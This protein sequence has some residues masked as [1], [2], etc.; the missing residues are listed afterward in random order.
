M[1]ASHTPAARAADDAARAARWAAVARAGLP[2]W[3][4]RDGAER[5]AR[6][7]ERAARA[8]RAAARAE[9]DGRNANPA[10]ERAAAAARSAQ[11]AAG[12]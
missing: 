4:P 1:Q 12:A 5:A 3:A 7:A 9:R 8:A 10:A 6:A 11:R 2:L